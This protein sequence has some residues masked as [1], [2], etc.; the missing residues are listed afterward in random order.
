MQVKMVKVEDLISDPANARTH[1]ARNIQA[2]KDSLQLF[3][4][5]KPIVIDKNNKVLAGN[6]TLQSAKELGWEKISTV[7]TDLDS[8]D[9]VGFSIAD[10]RTAE[11]ASWDN[12][13]LSTL[14]Q[15]LDEDIVDKLAIDDLNFSFND[16]QDEMDPEAEWTDLPEFV[17]EDKMGIRII[18]HFEDEDAIKEFGELI[19]QK[20]TVKTKSTWHPFKA[21]GEFVDLGWDTEENEPK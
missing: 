6:G 5:Q 19:G 11:L 13:V 3:G 9:A 17:Q 18:F 7:T 14:M 10:N 16:I 20:L 2:I 4:Q 8:A 1:S 12:D 15:N 21:R